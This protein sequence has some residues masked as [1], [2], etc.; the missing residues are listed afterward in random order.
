MNVYERVEDPWGEITEAAAL[1]LT[2]ARTA[3]KTMNPTTKERTRK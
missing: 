3:A 2:S 1:T